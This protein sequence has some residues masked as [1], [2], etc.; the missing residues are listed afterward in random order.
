MIDLDS[1]YLKALA[2]SQVPR[3][4]LTYTEK[5]GEALNFKVIIILIFG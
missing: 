3:I 4:E 5:P 2:F 1:L